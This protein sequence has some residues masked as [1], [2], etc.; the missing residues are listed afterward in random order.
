MCREAGYVTKFIFDNAPE[1]KRKAALQQ[2]TV[3]SRA[4]SSDCSLPSTDETSNTWL[5]ES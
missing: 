4:A 3:P 1:A 2:D 5:G